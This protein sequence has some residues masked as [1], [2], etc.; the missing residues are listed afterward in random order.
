MRPKRL[1]GRGAFSLCKKGFR[2]LG[3]EKKEKE[4]GSGLGPKLNNNF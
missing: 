1:V 4:G 3:R 2:R